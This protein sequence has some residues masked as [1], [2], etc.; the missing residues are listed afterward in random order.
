M[1]DK[2][3]E[4]LVCKLND[5][6]SLANLFAHLNFTFEK[7]RPVDKDTW[8]QE[9][10]NIVEEAFKIASKGGYNIYYIRT[11]TDSI[12]KWKSVSTKIIKANNG[13]C[14]VCSHNPDGFKWIF[15][16]LAK[17]F[18]QSFTETRHIPIDIRPNA[19]AP[20]TFV[21]F[22][23]QIILN[24][25]DTAISISIKVSEAFDTFAIQIHN[26]LTIN[27]FEALKIL[28]EGI[29]EEND[30][31][32]LNSETLEDIR[33]TVFTLLYRLIFILYAEDRGIFP[34]DNP[35]YYKEFS[36]RWIR[37]KWLLASIPPKISEYM[38][39]KRLWKF[40]KLIE[41]GSEDLGYDHNEFFMTSYYGRLFDRHINPKL[42][43]WKIK[44]HHLFKTLTLL[45]QTCDKQGNCFFLNYSA[46]ETRHLGSIYERL[47]EYHLTIKDN[48]IAPL[49]NSQDRKTSGSYY[50]PQYIVDH[51]V[52][53]TIG[54]LIDDIV[55]NI[56]SPDDQIEKILE[57]NIIDPAMGS[58]H[59]LIGVI[60]YMAN[61]ICEIEHYE[62]FTEEKLVKRKRDVARRCI[63]GVD[64]NSLAVDL[65]H[66]SL[67]LETLS[68]EKPLSF[69]SARLKTGNSLIGIR[70][71]D[72]LDKQTTLLES[73]Q[74]SRTHFKKIIKDFMMLENLE[75]D[76][77]SAV[78]TKIEKYI[79][80]QSSGTVYSD[81]KILLDAKLCKYF[82]VEIPPLGDYIQK[83]GKNSIDVKDDMWVLIKENSTKHAFFH[84]D[85]EFPNIFYD[86]SGE[87]KLDPG[88]DV[89][90]G[91]PPYIQKKTFSNDERKCIQDIFPNNLSN[92]NTAALFITQARRLIRKYKFIGMIIPKSLTFSKSWL[93]DRQKLCKNLL[94]IVDVSTA[95]KNVR[96]E[97]IIFISKKDTQQNFYEII[98]L[99]QNQDSIQMNKNLINTIDIIPTNIDNTELEI[100]EKI[101][102]NS[103]QLGNITDTF[104]GLPYQSQLKKTGKYAIIG[105]KEIARYDIKGIKGYFSESF[106]QTIKDKIIKFEQPKIITQDIVAHVKRPEAHVIITST[107]DETNTIPTNTLNC[108]TL[109]DPN[110]NLK[111]I[112]AIL[113][114]ELIS[115]YSYR[116][117]FNKAIRT[118]HLYKFFISKIPIS[119][120]LQFYQNPISKISTIIL[121]LNKQP[122][123]ILSKK[124]IYILNL[125]IFEIYFEEKIILNKK[126]DNILSEIFT[127]DSILSTDLIYE[128]VKLCFEKEI[129][130]EILRISSHKWFN[131]VTNGIY[132]DNI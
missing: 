64:V 129:K 123:T 49:P 110:H 114:S 118:M 96:L 23:E 72:I 39:Q 10:K 19:G 116:F 92:L 74:G 104:C 40:F 62:D 78:K 86:A 71:D 93:R 30:A 51:I 21:E 107:L 59:F 22:L 47:L 124:I 101:Y 80:M 87:K 122:N 100:F 36:F 94:K 17:N 16:S 113:N 45:T 127:D 75:D 25:N 65:A 126:I 63:Y 85:L 43:K 24:K 60:N 44:N 27:V 88:F 76:T 99:K 97:Q 98:F 9:D 54:P 31:L 12:K 82:S 91:N 6:Y 52:K 66:V 42:G 48:K 61:R 128:F 50:T 103:F 108:T 84:W 106:Y 14:I 111:S 69:L 130:K 79:N 38:V 15:S 121:F 81:L 117:I 28:S 55:K 41:L 46:L 83:I 90:L 132:R 58:G 53:N 70:L 89:V 120:N 2:K 32:T 119:R 29:I 112:L 115:W 73:F 95:W 4:D 109:S 125:M 68:S 26:E 1:I 8:N 37:K 131:I 5:Q 105:G 77:P 3:L 34:I 20:K 18:S 33:K 11:K 57:L 13:Q 102:N 35:I 67:W 7:Y 56:K